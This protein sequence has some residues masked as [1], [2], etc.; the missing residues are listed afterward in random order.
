[1]RQYEQILNKISP[2]FH[3]FLTYRLYFFSDYF[4]LIL[5]YLEKI[6]FSCISYYF[7]A[8]IPIIKTPTYFLIIDRWGFEKLDIYNKVIRYPS[9]KL[10]GS[11]LKGQ[12][13]QT[14]Y[15]EAITDLILNNF[16]FE[17]ERKDHFN[18]ECHETF[19][20]LIIAAVGK[21]TYETIR[22]NIK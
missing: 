7:A 11:Y 12:F 18:E 20:D 13:F 15:D 14:T 17:N 5:S 22:R 10:Y 19:K 8:D 16:S 3:K 6:K 1:M 9:I 2:V 4:S 21:D